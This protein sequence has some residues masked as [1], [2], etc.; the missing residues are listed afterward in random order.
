MSIKIAIT[1]EKGGVAKTTTAVNVAAIL[2]E[3]GYR[4]LLVDLDPQCLASAFYSLQDNT[5]PN[6]N[7]V[8]QGRVSAKAA[9]QDCGFFG[10]QMI[11]SYFSFEDIDDYFFKQKDKKEFILKNALQNIEPDYDF[12]IIDC[13]PSGKYIKLNA[14]AFADYIILPTMAEESAIQG[15]LCLSSKM[16]NIVRFINPSLAVLGVLIVMDERTAVKK[17]YKEALQ[18]QDIFP[19]FKTSIRKNTKLQETSNAHQPITVYEPKSN[20]SLDYKSLADEILDKLQLR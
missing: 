20:G 1:Y 19:C 18:E 7:D 9:I 17:I 5:L 11:P 8:M 15:L 14:M 2:A 6:I 16:E 13:P 12:I 3:Q 10:L 4:V